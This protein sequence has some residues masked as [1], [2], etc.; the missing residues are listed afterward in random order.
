MISTEK[1]INNTSEYKGHVTDRDLDE[2]GNGITKELP[3][4]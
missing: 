1:S 2:F 3:I 4:L